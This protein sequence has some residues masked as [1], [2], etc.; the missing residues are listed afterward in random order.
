M[1]IS[2]GLLNIPVSSFAELVD[3]EQDVSE[4]SEEIR[5]LFEENTKNR[6]ENSNDLNTD[7]LATDEVLDI[8]PA[9][10]AVDDQGLSTVVET[11]ELVFDEEIDVVPAQEVIDVQDATTVAE[12]DGQDGEE[13]FDGMTMLYIGG[14]IGVVALGVLAFSGGSSSGSSSPDTPVPDPIDPPI[15]PDVNGNWSGYLEIKDTGHEGRQ[16]ISAKITHSGSSV[17]IITTSTLDY[18]RRFSGT[19]S[20]SGYM[21]VYD[22]D[23]GEDWTTHY[24]NASSHKMD[25][26]DYV[27]NFDDLDRMFLAK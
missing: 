3:Q 5:T 6:V 13:E 21:L 1:I 27:N 9:L 4:F 18:G 22:A 16:N 10:E 2:M 14:A 19:I 12:S 7:V 25:L 26:Y 20:R 24:G 15:G 23:R 17:D 8:D 11:E